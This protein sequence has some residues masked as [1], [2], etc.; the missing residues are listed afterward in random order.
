MH[1]C[2]RNNGKEFITKTVE[3]EDED[4]GEQHNM[5]I[6]IL[7][8]PFELRSQK[9]IL[10]YRK[11]SEPNKVPVWLESRYSR[12]KQK[13]YSTSEQRKSRQH[14]QIVGTTELNLKGLNNDKGSSAI[15]CQLKIYDTWS[16]SWENQGCG[17][18]CVCS[19]WHHI[20]VSYNK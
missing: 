1:Q 2:A 15:H 8:G 19:L 18:L 17:E 20:L 11:Q 10:F 4:D 6:W 7:C 5:L 14:T 3:R 9:C 16:E 12:P 13:M